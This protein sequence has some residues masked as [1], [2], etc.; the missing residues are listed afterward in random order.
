MVRVSMRI[1]VSVWLRVSE[2]NCEGKGADKADKGDSKGADKGVGKGKYE[3]MGVNC[4]EDKNNGK[5]YHYRVVQLIG[6]RLL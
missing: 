3:G 1:R 6:P 4:C 5:G 2:D